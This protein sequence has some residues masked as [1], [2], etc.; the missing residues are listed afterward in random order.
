MEK[1]E[2]YKVVN[3]LILPLFTGSIIDGEQESSARDSEVAFEK[4]NTLLIKPSK[5]D[6]YRLILKRGRP[7]QPF[8][9]NLL[10][11]ILGELEQISAL[12]IQEESFTKVLQENAIEKAICD[13]IC[14]G[15][16][17]KSM[18]GIINHLE[19][20]SAR[21]YEGSRVAIGII[22]NLSSEVQ[23]GGLNYEEVMNQD[24]FSLLSDGEQSYVEFD[25]KGNLLGYVQ[26]DKVKKVPC[27]SPC[28]Y[29]MIARY[30]N[31]RRIGIVLTTYGDLLIFKNRNLLFAKR[32]GDWNIYSH[33]EVI[34]LLANRGSYSLKDI[35]RSVYYT[36]LDTSFAYCGG[37]IVYLNKDGVQGAL[38]HINAQD[39][40]SE[41][42]YE[43]K[44]NLEIENAINSNNKKALA[45]VESRY[46][47]PYEEFLKQNN[48][49]KSRT[50]RRIIDNKPFHELSRKLRSEIVGM[51]G[52]TIVDS[53]GT[54]VATGA[55]LKI[56]AGSEGG[57]RLA[58]ATTLGKYGVSIKISQDGLMKAFFPDKK[59][60]KVKSLFTVG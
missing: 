25:K 10:K 1:Q 44:K 53:D 50:I 51:D 45:L 5:T 23:E 6:E 18:F 7:F 36:A 49:I 19:N 9:V 32:L 55:I 30:C 22:L 17:A 12:G 35:R 42:Y 58:A 39:I 47:L 59:A 33:E 11:S 46:S 3:K 38:A 2:F 48:C 20:W 57:G 29:E 31:E 54:I 26:L 21:T 13:S 14:D 37:C 28:S 34:Q 24:F 41:K 40:L 60:G 43:M 27:I 56:E 4:R 16:S 52:A 15:E 8:E